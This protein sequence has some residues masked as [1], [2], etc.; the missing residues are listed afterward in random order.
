MA[1][2]YIWGVCVMDGRQDVGVGA[3]RNRYGLFRPIHRQVI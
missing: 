1:Q 2:D 3:N